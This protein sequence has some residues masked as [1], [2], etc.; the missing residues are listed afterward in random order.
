MSA[1]HKQTGVNYCPKSKQMQFKVLAFA[2]QCLS[3]TEALV[4]NAVD[5]TCVLVRCKTPECD[6]DIFLETHMWESFVVFQDRQKLEI[7]W[8]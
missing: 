5:N 8:D 7:E 6:G 3:S 1:F 4:E 2:S